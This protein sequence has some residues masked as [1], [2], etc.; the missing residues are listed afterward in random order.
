MRW[1]LGILLL[2]LA[3]LLLEA[4]LLAYATYVLLGLLL[5]SRLL[6]RNWIANVTATRSCKQQTAEIGDQVK[7]TVTVRNAGRLPVPWVIL[8]DLLPRGVTAGPTP[9]LKIARGKRIQVRMLRGNG[10][11]KLDYQIDCRLRGY[12][13]VGPLLLESGDLFGLH[14]RHRVATEPF[15]LLVYPKV[16]P[17][18]GY[19]LASRRPIGDVRLTH[20]LYEDP[21]RIAGVRA[22]EA[23]DPL[24]RV[25]WRATARTGALHCK[26]YEPSTL[27]GATVLLDF[28]QAGYPRR[29]EPHRSELAVTTAMSLVHVLYQMGQQVGLVSNGR[30]AADRIRLEGWDH[31]FRT[32]Q[33]ARAQ[34]AMQEQSQRL[35]PVVVETRRGVEQFQRIRETLA[36]IELTDGFTF[37]Q[38]VE[39][40]MPRVPRDATLL[41]VLP[42]VAVETALTLGNLRR[43]GFAVTVVLIQC[44]VH[45]LERCYGRLLAEGV[46]DVRHLAN[47]AG[48]PELCGRQ[49]LGQPAVVLE[50]HDGQAPESDAPDWA[51]RTTYH[52]EHVEE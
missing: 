51:Q 36:R 20:R 30:D 47:E 27:A 50:S 22:Y 52:T 33:T 16:V 3:A 19:D 25:H 5:V 8:E 24:N 35:Q 41:A 28:H 2:L 17:I 49:A 46:R 18:Q 29:G 45:Q 7:M 38:L 31:D 32:R 43:R 13:Q 21:T 12:Y 10:K 11:A 37:A 39:E 26:V 9:R 40:T 6:A 44:D 4:G 34:T 1:F 48:L 23:G 14:R 15:F 42:D